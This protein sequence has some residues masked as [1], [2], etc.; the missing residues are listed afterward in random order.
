MGARRPVPTGKRERPLSVRSAD[1]RQLPGDD[2]DA[3]I[4]VIRAS[5]I[6]P[7]GSIPKPASPTRRW[8]GNNRAY[9]RLGSHDAVLASVARFFAAVR[10]ALWGVGGPVAVPA[11]A[12]A[13]ARA[14]ARGDRHRA[15]RRD[16]Y[17][18]CRRSD[19]G[20]AR[21][22]ARRGKT[23]VGRLRRIRRHRCTWLLAGSWLLAVA[24]GDPVASIGASTP[25]P[26]WGY[27]GSGRR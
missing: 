23:S 3:P 6:E 4:S 15:S 9:G 12:A 20:L 17:P 25:C 14:A 21:R 22:P 1:R 16:C 26:A 2:D 8:R 10:C 11:V 19:G 5:V 27:A 13:G 24:Y 7:L 18:T